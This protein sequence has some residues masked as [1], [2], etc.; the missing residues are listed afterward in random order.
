MLYGAIASSGIG[1]GTAYMI[2][3]PRIV[4]E[5]KTGMN[6]RVEKRRFQAAVEDFVQEIRKASDIVSRKAGRSEAEILETQIGLINDLELRNE[7]HK[8]LYHE[9]VNVEYAFSTVCDRYIGLFTAMDDALFRARA[10]DLRDLKVSLLSLLMGL[11]KLDLSRIPLGSVIVS[12]DL[13]PSSAVSIDPA[14]IRGIVTEEGAACSHFSI[15]SRAM[16]LPTVVAV[17]GL[18]EH[19]RAGD[20]LIVDGE[21]GG[22]VRNPG[23]G[24]LQS[25]ME[26]L[27][28]AM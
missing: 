6:P 4:V 28:Q 10:A 9:R 22:V 20:T 13:P 24:L 12:R 11:G 2:R 7:I 18:M 16:D 14:R 23:P 8:I 21:S 19:V 1:I 27:A 15:L 3:Q 5:H 26:L 25:Y 17:D